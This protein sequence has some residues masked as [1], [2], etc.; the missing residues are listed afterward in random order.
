M[1]GRSRKGPP[2]HCRRPVGAVA[3]RSSWPRSTA[4]ATSAAPTAG[5]RRGGGASAHR[6]GGQQAHGVIVALGAVGG[7]IGIGH[8]PGEF[9]GVATLAAAEVISGHVFRIVRFSRFERG[10]NPHALVLNVLYGERWW[11]VR[12]EGSRERGPGAAGVGWG[13]SGLVERG[14]GRVRQGGGCAGWAGCG[15]FSPFPG[16]VMVAVFAARVKAMVCAVVAGPVALTRLLQ[17]RSGRLAGNGGGVV[18]GQGPSGRQAAAG[19]PDAYLLVWLV[20]WRASPWASAEQRSAR[21]RFWTGVGEGPPVRR[22]CVGPVSFV[23]LLPG[24]RKAIS[25]TLGARSISCRC[26]GWRVT[27]FSGVGRP[28]SSAPHPEHS[29]T[30]GGDDPARFALPTRRS[31]PVRCSSFLN[32]PSRTDHS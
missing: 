9:E 32:P 22:P 20:S 27:V 25:V 12:G 21:T 1:R 11:G 23:I 28:R 10:E 13:C 19:R 26:C 17:R 24:S 7:G 14:G 31:S 6:D 16:R 30:H 18:R 2:L 3:R 8:G 4:A 5:G 29:P 15:W